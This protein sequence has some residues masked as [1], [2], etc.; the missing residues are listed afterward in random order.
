[1]DPLYELNGNSGTG[2]SIP[3]GGK[4]ALTQIEELIK[5]MK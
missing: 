5:K 2:I 4:E 1:L 3:M